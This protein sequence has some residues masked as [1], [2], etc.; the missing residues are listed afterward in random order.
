MIWSTEV[1]EM[2]KTPRSLNS[3]GL[4]SSF[5]LLASM[6]P[7]IAIAFTIHS[8]IIAPSKCFELHATTSPI[9]WKPQ[10]QPRFDEFAECTVGP[11]VPISQSVDEKVP[12]YDVEEVMRSCG[13]AVQGIKELPLNLLYPDLSDVTEDRMYH[14]RADSGFVYMNDGSYSAG[15]EQY[16]LEQ[17][18]ESVRSKLFMSSLSFGRHRLWLALSLKSLREAQNKCVSLE[19]AA[20]VIKETS[21]LA[22]KRPTSSDCQEQQLEHS[23]SI[24]EVTWISALRVRMPSPG[25]P[26][27]LSRAKWETAIL[28]NDQDEIDK[29]ESRTESSQQTPTKVALIGSAQVEVFTQSEGSNIVFGDLVSEGNILKMQAVSLNTKHAQSTIRCYDEHGYLR[30]V[31]FLEGSIKHDSVT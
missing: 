18:D 31:A 28:V 14:N 6:S 9:Q 21:F 27:S 1:T 3:L 30:S 23:R 26:W 17:F 10:A 13:G 19:D 7:N 25:Q 4:A 15:P 5:C 12:K 8:S 2:M 24:P 16:S 22:V 11:W 29:Y 20:T